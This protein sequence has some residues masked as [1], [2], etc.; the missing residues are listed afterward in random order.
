[1]QFLE[2]FI[3]L[4]V[5]IDS[6]GMIPVFLGMTDHLPK[7]LRRRIAFEA[8]LWA[9]LIAIA[10]MLL[11]N[12]IFRHLGIT[13]ADFRIAGGVILLVYAIKEL[14][15]TARVNERDAVVDETDTTMAVVPLALPLIAGPATLTLVLVLAQRSTALTALSLAANFAILL[16][17]MIFAS[18]IG[19][20]VGL[21][22][23]RAFSKLVMVLLAAIA[24]NFIRVGV[25]E[26]I[27]AGSGT[28]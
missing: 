8:T 4:F 3:P 16:A 17:L 24:V 28:G 21:K 5:A 12:W 10:F 2:F 7:A 11:G 26:I 25:M 9:T 15:F 22:T 19:T 18:R 6:I 14:T 20:F 13:S 27:A 1:M 23:F